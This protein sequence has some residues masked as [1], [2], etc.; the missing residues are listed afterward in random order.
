MSMEQQALVLEIKKYSAIARS[1]P[2]MCT[3]GQ[4]SS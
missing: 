1:I 3:V 2:R 4:M